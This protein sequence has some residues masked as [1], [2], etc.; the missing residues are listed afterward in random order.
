M[1]EIVIILVKEYN[2]IE[3]DMTNI[4]KFRIINYAIHNDNT[5]LFD[6]WEIQKI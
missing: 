2:I 1:Q 4:L 3:S 5:H 6:V